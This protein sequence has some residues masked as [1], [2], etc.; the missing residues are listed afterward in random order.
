MSF[1]QNLVENGQDSYGLFG[2]VATPINTCVECNTVDCSECVIRATLTVFV[3]KLHGTFGCFG[4]FGFVLCLRV[5][6]CE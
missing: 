3:M 1:N 2:R 5:S 4:P 6:E